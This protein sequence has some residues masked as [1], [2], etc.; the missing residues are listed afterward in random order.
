MA[1][2]IT[3]LDTVRLGPHICEAF[4]TYGIYDTLNNQQMSY[5]FGPKCGGR[6]ARCQGL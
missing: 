3:G 1:Y 2:F 4:Y 5:I 6:A